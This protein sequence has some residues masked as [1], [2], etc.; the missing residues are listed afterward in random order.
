VRPR[1]DRAQCWVETQLPAGQRTR[2]HEEPD[3]AALDALSDSERGALKLLVDGLDEHWSLDGLS[4]LVYAVPKLQAGLAAD[5]K[6]TPELK[7]AQRQFFA[8]VYR[9]LI[10]TD[11]G[12]RLPTLLLAAGPARVRALLGG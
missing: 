11:T 1:L 8:L 9:L 7:V 5:A 3:H 4:Q 2:L 12:P 10:G 6:P